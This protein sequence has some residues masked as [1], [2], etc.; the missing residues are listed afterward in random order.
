MSNLQETPTPTTT[1]NETPLGVE[2]PQPYPLPEGATSEQQAEYDKALGLYK[3]SQQV[4]TVKEGKDTKTI[5]PVAAVWRNGI[6][7][8]LYATDVA[9]AK[10]GSDKEGWAYPAPHV[11]WA[12]ENAQAFFSWIGAPVLVRW[13][14]SKVKQIAQNLAEE[15]CQDLKD[16]AGNI[17]YYMVKGKPTEDAK[18]DYT[19][20]DINAFLDLMADLSPRSETLADINE[21]IYA[22]AEEMTNLDITE[23]ITA[24]SGDAVAGVA[25]YKKDM[26]NLKT[27]VMSYKSAKDK[28]KRHK[29]TTLEEGA[30]NGEQMEQTTGQVN[31]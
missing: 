30:S 23:Y 7:V 21:A 14:A 11:Q 16:S 25:A 9:R 15:A 22:L 10:K 3:A 29:T 27:Q 28:K 24:A 17:Q 1:N 4:I 2:Y 19:T 5:T 26:D 18:P 20:F 12:K 31:A 13:A 8:P 6:A